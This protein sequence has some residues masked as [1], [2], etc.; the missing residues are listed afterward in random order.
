MKCKSDDNRVENVSFTGTEP[1]RFQV[2]VPVQHLPVSEFCERVVGYS[3]VTTK[4]LLNGVTVEVE[5][6][7]RGTLPIYDSSPRFFKVLQAAT[8]MDSLRLTNVRKAAL[9]AMKDSG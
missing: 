5:R 7:P 3:E 6:V 8:K 1:V 4:V 9:S 2:R